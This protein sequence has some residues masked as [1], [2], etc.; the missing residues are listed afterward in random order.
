MKTWKS[1]FKEQEP[2]EDETP[3]ISKSMSG[4]R[5][6]LLKAAKINGIT[7]G[8]ALLAIDDVLFLFDAIIQKKTYDTTMSNAVNKLVN[9]LKKGW[10]LD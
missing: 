10:G 1:L 7:S 9:I 5:A 3:S 2:K 6:Y 4:A 8:R